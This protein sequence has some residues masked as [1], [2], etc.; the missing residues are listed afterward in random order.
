MPP[1]SRAALPSSPCQPAHW[2][3]LLPRT[4]RLPGS[5]LW[6]CPAA[7]RRRAVVAMAAAMRF[8]GECKGG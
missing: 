6:A 7:A 8:I 4:A 1:L 2:H 3:P 5:S